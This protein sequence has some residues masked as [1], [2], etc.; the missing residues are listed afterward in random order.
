MLLCGDTSVIV[1]YTHSYAYSRQL[2][3]VMYDFITI[4]MIITLIILI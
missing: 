2:R 1:Y 4:L 3:T